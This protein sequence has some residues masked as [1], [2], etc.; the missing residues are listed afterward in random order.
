MTVFRSTGFPRVMPELLLLLGNRDVFNEVS[1]Q[2]K[3]SRQYPVHG[4]IELK[5]AE[6][7]GK[8]V[9]LVSA[10]QLPQVTASIIEEA[11]IAGSRV[12]VKIGT[13]YSVSHSLATGDVLIP[14]AAI[15]LEKVSDFFAPKEL[16]AL[17]DDELHSKLVNVL[18]TLELG[19]EQRR[20]SY[21]STTEGNIRVTTG[22]VA[23][24]TYMTSK[25]VNSNDLI[26][27]IVRHPS[28]TAVDS[29]TA[30]LYVSAYEKPV[31]TA[32]VLLVE[33]KLSDI[34]PLK[35]VQEEEWKKKYSFLKNVLARITMKIIENM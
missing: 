31:K 32:S 15:R 2:L 16:P 28:I 10:P 6:W 12:I 5:I 35:L 13:A 30:T 26:S 3:I 21:Q 34:D 29:D 27:T 24:I 14:R 17:P 25:F 8:E 18:S 11:T 23:S 1:R 19:D 4:F 22:L 9:A 20:L 33:G 7:S